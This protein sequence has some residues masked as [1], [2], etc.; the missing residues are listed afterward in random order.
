MSKQFQITVC[1]FPT[2]AKEKPS[3]RLAAQWA[4]ERSVPL[5]PS[6][7]K[8]PS[9][10]RDVGYQGVTKPALCFY[11]HRSALITSLFPLC[12]PTSIADSEQHG[13]AAQVFH[14]RAAP[15][16]PGNTAQ[17]QILF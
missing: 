13:A 5:G 7:E 3:V 16:C 2:D 15:I 10:S 11:S 6:V 9:G 14:I 8:S 1:I 12:D 4:K 17:L